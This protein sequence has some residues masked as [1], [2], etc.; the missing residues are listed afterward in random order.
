VSEDKDV[1]DIGE[2]EGIKIITAA[3]FLAVLAAEA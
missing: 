3:V 2:Y 1:L